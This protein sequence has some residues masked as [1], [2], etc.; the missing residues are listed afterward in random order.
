MI[1]VNF[2]YGGEGYLARPGSSHSCSI[3]HWIQ[4]HSLLFRSFQQDKAVSLQDPHTSQ[5]LELRYPFLR[6]QDHALALS[7]RLVARLFL[8]SDFYQ[9]NLVFNNVRVLHTSL[10][11]VLISV[12]LNA[13]L[14]S[15]DLA[16]SP[17]ETL[18]KTLLICN[19]SSRSVSLELY[20]DE[21]DIVSH[22][23]NSHSISP[24]LYFVLIARNLFV[25]FSI[26]YKLY[27]GFHL[28]SLSSFLQPH[29]WNVG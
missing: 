17:L 14:R 1:N 29:D 11:I 2:R 10:T 12:V 18:M 15:S 28:K 25:S 3:W 24:F 13:F 20:M 9:W 27:K 22:K 5:R 21:I 23:S 19:T 7:H 16:T 6:Q 8:G 26:I 4:L